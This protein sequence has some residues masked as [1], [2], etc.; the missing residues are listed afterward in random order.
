MSA[1]ARTQT[2]P[3]V[4]CAKPWDLKPQP[5][6]VLQKRQSPKTQALLFILPLHFR[7]WGEPKRV[8]A[9]SCNFLQAKDRMTAK[10]VTAPGFV[11]HG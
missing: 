3:S 11:L 1:E 9:Q 5:L 2:L 4:M 10:D 8:A 6:T 7:S